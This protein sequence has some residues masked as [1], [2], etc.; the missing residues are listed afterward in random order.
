MTTIDHTSSLDPS[1]VNA[2]DR[3]I[4]GTLMYGRSTAAPQLAKK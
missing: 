1:A 2:R 4:L 3:L